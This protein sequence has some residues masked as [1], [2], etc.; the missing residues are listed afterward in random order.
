VQELLNIERLQEMR[1]FAELG[2]MSAILLHEITNP[3]AAALLNLESSDH[4]SVAI[5]QARRDMQ[6]MKRYIEAARSQ[7][8]QH[9]MIKVFG[10]Q[11][12]LNQ[13]KRIANPLARKAGV[14]LSISSLSGCR[15]QGDPVKFQQIIIN[16]IK[17]AIDAY[18]TAATGDRPLTVSLMQKRDCLII[19]VADRATGIAAEALPRLF[20]EFYTTKAGPA[21]GLGL[22]LAI[23][24]RYATEDFHGTVEVSSDKHGTRFTVTLPV[25]A[26]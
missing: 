21:A 5:R 11:P 24:K 17:N 12:Q 26:M 22:G 3:L 23:V 18:Q 20:D 19:T 14:Q 25:P 13:L 8:P 16:L 6:L 4:K 9:S 2:R 10:V 7:V 1:H 15:L